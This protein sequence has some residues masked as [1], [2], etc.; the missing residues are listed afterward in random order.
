M[1]QSGVGGRLDQ[2]NVDVVKAR[3]GFGYAM[4]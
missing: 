2:G 1:K 4:I 3:S